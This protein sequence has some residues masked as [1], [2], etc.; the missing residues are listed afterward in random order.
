MGA[1]RFACPFCGSDFG[2]DVVALA[3]H[4]RGVHDLP[5]GAAPRGAG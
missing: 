2:R 4:I 1:Y 5:R 3:L